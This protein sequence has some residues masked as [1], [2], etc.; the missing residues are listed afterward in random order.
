[1]P[2][3]V[4]VSFRFIEVDVASNRYQY[5]ETSKPCIVVQFSK[6]QRVDS[7]FTDPFMVMIP[8]VEQ[9]TAQYTISTPDQNERYFE[10]YINIVIDTKQID[11]LRLDG[12]TLRDEK[13]VPIWGRYISII[14]IRDIP[15][16][17]YFESV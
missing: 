8:P 4:F 7:T 11:G 1:M 12:R 3:T 6:G 13:W 5:I 15:N 16:R 14:K 17:V 9:Y 10:S 2:N